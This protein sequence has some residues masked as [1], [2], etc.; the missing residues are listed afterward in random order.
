VAGI[1]LVAVVGLRAVTDLSDPRHPRRFTLLAEVALALTLVIVAVALRRLGLYQQ[2]Y[3]LTMLR[4]YSSV[5]AVWIGVVLLFAGA[6]LAGVGRGRAWFPA[7]AGAAGLVLLLVL[8]IADPEAV[9]VRHNVDRAARTQKV[10]P[11]YLAELSDDAV[12]AL[13]AALPRLPEPARGEVVAA[14]CDAASEP[15]FDGIWSANTS[16]RRAVDARRQVCRP[17]VVRRSVP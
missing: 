5:F 7:A 4:L 12:P 15:P 10:D 17:G 1:T 9:V 6:A 8:N 13:V 2:A 14:V 16:R 3:G 11:G